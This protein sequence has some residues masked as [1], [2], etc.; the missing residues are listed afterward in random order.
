M[1]RGDVTRR[2]VLVG[3]GAA[4]V[5]TAAVGAARAADAPS[6]P[7]DATKV[8]GGASTPRSERSPFE[9]PHVTPVGKVTGPAFSPIQ[10]LVGSI[11]PTDLQFQRHHGGIAQIDPKR[12]KLLVHGLVERPLVFTLDDLKRFPAVSRVHFLECAGNGRHAYRDGKPDMTVQSFD[13]LLSNVEWTGV[14]LSLLLREAGVKP[15]ASWFVGEGG[16]AAVMAR[17]VPLEKAWDDALVVYAANGEAL[18]PAHGYPL[19]LFLPGFEANT[20]VKWLRRIEVTDQPLMSKDE[21]SKYTDP[22]P[23]DRARQFSFV[24]DCKSTITAPTWPTTLS[25]PG[26]WPI[27][28]LAWSGRGRITRVEV[29]VD[30]GRSWADAELQGEPLPK[31]VVRF[32]LPWVWDGKPARL[33]SRATDETGYVQPTLA[34]FRE[35]RG[36]GTDFH[37][38]YIRT[39]DVGADGAV[40][41]VPDPEAT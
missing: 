18:R 12:H 32:V 15:G 16:D 6:V 35:A 28:G 27:Q 34:A 39:W 41:F 11:T 7:D 8:L 14:P 36:V 13:G 3:L 10:E 40:V 25:G 2:D 29:S 24:M 9:D 26:S 37:F 17:S 30:G 23:G 20:C 4:S 19:R 38:N 31:A 5:A 1:S 22:L 33:M 21:T